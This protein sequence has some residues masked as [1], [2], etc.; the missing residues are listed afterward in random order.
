[1][2]DISYIDV[3]VVR[4]GVAT[5]KLQHSLEFLLHEDKRLS[6]T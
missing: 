1:M 3:H 6:P 5:P 2:K 4:G